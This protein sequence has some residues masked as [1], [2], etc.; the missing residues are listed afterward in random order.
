MIRT[1]SLFLHLV[2]ENVW[3]TRDGKYHLMTDHKNLLVIKALDNRGEIIRY[4][5]RKIIA[6]QVKSSDVEL[7]A[8]FSNLD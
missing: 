5:D 3:N 4:E 7:F 8:L 6:H 2:G 1:T